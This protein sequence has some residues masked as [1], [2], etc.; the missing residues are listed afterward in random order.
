MATTIKLKNSV[1]TTNVPSS[2]AQGEVAINVTDKKVWVGNAATTPVQLLGTGADGSFT[3]L[4]Y[5]G[6]LTGGTGIVNLGS[7]QVYK[8]ASGNLGIGTASPNSASVNKA[9]T[10]SGTSNAI[11]EL[12]G[13]ATR[14]GYLFASTATGATILSA[15]PA[16]SILQFNTVD[17]ERMRIDSSG[18]VGIGTSSGNTKFTVQ[19]AGGY[20]IARFTTSDYADGSAGSGILINTGA[21]TGNTY[22][23]INAYQAGFASSNNLILQ[24]S[25]GNVGIGTS[26]PGGRLSVV[27]SG[28]AGVSIGQS[29]ENFYAA[30]LH[31]FFDLS[32]VNERMRIDTSGNL[33]V[34]TTS[35]INVTTGSATGAY[36]TPNG[37]I[38]SSTSNDGSYFRRLGA[39][40]NII[41]F[42]KGTSSVGSISVTASATSFNTSSDYRLKENIAPMTGALGVVQQLKPVTYNWKVDGSSGQGFIAHE[43]AEVVPD[44][45]TGEKDAVDAEGNPVYQGIDTSFLV[46]TLTASIQELKAIVDAQAERIAVLESK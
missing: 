45:V 40:G 22:T 9:I 34:G 28:G 25:G 21:T 30:S 13:G 31:R 24:N 17:T 11:L 10:I 14:A 33:L 29:N 46:A 3:N 18:N 8:D 41:A 36:F 16:A 23:S 44:C 2:L 42:Y 6:T 38:V 5:S 43:L 7:G 26:S 15:V 37:T 39:D 19:G 32:Y 20:G 12:N 4:A 27:A 35:T 1:T